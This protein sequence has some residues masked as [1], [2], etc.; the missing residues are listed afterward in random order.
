MGGDV[1]QSMMEEKLGEVIARRGQLGIARMIERQLSRGQTDSETDAGTLAPW[2]T[3]RREI[4]RAAEKYDLSPKLIT[5]VIEQESGGDPQAVSQ[6]GARGVMQLMDTTATMLGVKNV[7]DP[8]ENIDA[9]SRYLKQQL[10]RFGELPLALAAYNAGPGAVEKY[11]GIPPY[12]E[13]RNYVRA[14]LARLNIIGNQDH[15]P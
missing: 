15:Q 3:I 10:D 13:T 1:F 8:A 6:A 12:A 11:G 4:S 2:D 14:I 7:F 9:G 5:A